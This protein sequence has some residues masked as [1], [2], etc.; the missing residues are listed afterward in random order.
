[1]VLLD[2]DARRERHRRIKILHEFVYV[3]VERLAPLRI[4]KVNLTQYLRLDF[5]AVA[6][7][8]ALLLEYASRIIAPRLRLEHLKML[9][10]IGNDALHV[11]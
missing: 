8:G 2:A 10:V 1:M 7:L 3:F 9:P 11:F 4:L 6:V 5:H